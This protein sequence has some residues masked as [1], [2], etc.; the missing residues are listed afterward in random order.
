M[1]ECGGILDY[2]EVVMFFFF[3]S[4]RR[5]H[6]RLTCGW[7]SDVCSSDLHFLP[8]LLS[9]VL[10]RKPRDA[11]RSFL[12]DDLQTLNHARHHDV[13]QT[14]IQILCVLTHNDQIELGI[15]TRHI[16]QCAHRTQVCVKV[17]CL[18]QSNIDR[19]KTF[20]DWRR[21]WSLERDLVA[22]DG[23]E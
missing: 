16:R 11:C 1:L 22:E 8:R 9:R 7:S 13:L 18:A 17:Q 5:R 10:K 21:D 6:T 12:C 23:I 4:S 19:S 20:A 15:S 14:R 2:L 3:F